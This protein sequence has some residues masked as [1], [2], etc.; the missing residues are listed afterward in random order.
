M[1]CDSLTSPQPI[2][3]NLANPAICPYGCYQIN[4]EFNNPG[5]DSSYATNLF[6]RYGANCN[7]AEYLIDL[8]DNYLTPMRSK[9]NDIQTKISSLNTGKIQPYQTQVSSLSSSLSSFK[10]TI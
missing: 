1:D 9:M 5:G 10:S 3:A 7:Y 4:E 2:C 8:Q 6:T